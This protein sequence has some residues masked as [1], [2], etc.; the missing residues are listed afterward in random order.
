MTDALPAGVTFVSASGNGADNGGVV[1]W[2]L[3]TLA[4]GAVSNLTLIVTAPANGSLANVASVGSPTSDPVPSNNTNPPVTTT[5]TPSADVAVGL[6][7]PA[8]VLGLNNF[9]CTIAVTNLGPSTAAGILVTDTLPAGVTF[10]SASGGGSSSGGTVKWNLGALLSGQ[11]SNVTVTVTAPGSGNLTNN[12]SAGA[13]TGDP[14]LPNN[15]AAWVT[16]VTPVAPTANGQSVA[17]LENTAKGITLTGSDPNSLPLTFAIGSNPAHGGLS[18]LN[19]NTGAVTYTPNANFAGADSFTFTVSNGLT[20]STPATVN[21]TVTPVADLAVFKSGPASGVAGSNLTYTV[22]VTN[23]GPAT[24]TNIVVSDQLPAGLT[25]VSEVPPAS[26]SGN[27]ANWT[28]ASLAAGAQTNFTVTAVSTGGGNFTNVAYAVAGTVDPNATNNNGTL[29]SSQTRTTVTP[30]ADVAVFKTGNASVAAGG[31]VIYTIVA[32]NAGPSTAANVVVKDNLPGGTTFVSAS[33][34]GTTNG[35]VV[36]WP[37]VA[38]ARGA[39]AS[40]TLTLIAPANGTLVNTALSTSDTADSNTNNNNGTAAA[41]KVST[42][43]TP[44]ADVI[45]LLSGPANVPLGSNAVYTIT[46][47][48]AG[49]SVASNVVVQDTFPAALVFGSASGG[50]TNAGGTVTW[51]ALVSLVNG[52]TTNFTLTLVAANSGVVTNRA[53]ATAATFDPNLTN[54]NGTLPASQAATVVAVPQFNV[55]AGTN[56]TQLAPGTYRVTTNAFNPQT[57]LYEEVVTVTNTG[58]TTVA[59]VRLLVSGLRSGVTLY[60]A[61]G[62]NGGTPYVEYDG[63]LNP[64][65][66]V[67]PFAVTFTLEF[68]DALRVAFT[69]TVTAVAILPPGTVSV[70]TNGVTVT[71]VFMDTRIA[72]DT[73][74]VVEWASVP[75]KSYTVIYKDSLVATN[76]LVATPAVTANANITQWYDD[77]PPKTTSKPASTVSRFYRVILNN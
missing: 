45:V 57:G 37:G 42:S 35:G 17:T 66:T 58:T 8:S 31:T 41:S 77:G 30:V 64:T 50:G 68:Y 54:N 47:T 59:G 40:Y 44:S 60:N 36:T 49:P 16:A 27:L 28:V 75:G 13:T 6:S 76:W 11:A 2:D 34:G 56:V 4:N 67:P 32:T 26:V 72:G 69:N 48:N 73:R 52:G 9:T 3:G 20:N 18:G 55:V 21:I 25:Y 22:T 29:A 70:G 23:L 61:T 19:P 43:V 51:P 12:A 7:G 14:N 33:G 24:A 74:F 62:T 71:N 63:P 5:I 10:V 39:A 46:V 65:N 1:T 15:S 38:L 53:F